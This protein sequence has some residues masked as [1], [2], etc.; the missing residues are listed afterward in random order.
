MAKKTKDDEKKD[1]TSDGTVAVNDAW[2]GLLIISLI[3]LM[4]GAGFL[5]WD[6]YMYS[7]KPLP[8]VPKLVG[9]PPGQP[10]QQQPPPP[11]KGDEKDK[12]KDKDK[13]M[14]PMPPMP[15]MP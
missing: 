5:G 8:T 12:D 10:G 2:T 9:T 3:A 1:A 4:V 14:P 15:P 11:G 6:Y 7:E 13:G